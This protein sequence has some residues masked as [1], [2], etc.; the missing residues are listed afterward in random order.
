MF[1]C[2]SIPNLSLHAWL[3]GGSPQQ[4]EAV[5]WVTPGFGF[6]IYSSMVALVKRPEIVSQ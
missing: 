5:S 3:D 4:V 6:A 2:K 1:L